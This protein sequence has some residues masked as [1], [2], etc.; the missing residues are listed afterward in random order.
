MKKWIFGIC[1]FILLCLLITNIV[2]ENI[3]TE[4]NIPSEEN[5]VSNNSL[6]YIVRDFNGNIAVFDSKG[7]QPIKITDVSTES[8]PAMD[9]KMLKDGV[10]VSGQNELNTLLEDLCS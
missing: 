4:Q 5:K 10:K 7:N 9:R 3:Q 8:L 6:T 1:G 2:F